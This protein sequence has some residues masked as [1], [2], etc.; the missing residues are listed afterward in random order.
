MPNWTGSFYSITKAQAEFTVNQYPNALTLRIRMPITGNFNERNF[1][2]KIAKYEKLINFPNSVTVLE[3]M[4]PVSID[5][6]L[7]GRK[8]V[9]NFT[10]PGYT[11]H[12]EVMQLYQKYVDPNKQFK[13]SVF[14]IFYC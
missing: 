8:G 1:V 4:L 14:L 2:C 6:T 11:T 12:N 13:V 10:N 3:D 9:F 7:D 5:M